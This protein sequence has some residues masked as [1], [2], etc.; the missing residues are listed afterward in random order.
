MDISKLTTNKKEQLAINPNTP[1]EALAEL[2]KDD[3]YNVRSGVA[4]NPN[5][6]VAILS[7]LAKDGDYGVRY[8]VAKNHN[9]PVEA[10][11]EILQLELRGDFDKYILRLIFN[12]KN[13]T[14]A[15]RAIIRTVC[16]GV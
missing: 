13:S 16:P 5:T 8:E 12:H 4:W 7:E 10:L 6:P 9:T 11:A 1:V 3:D 14:D 15:I 2:A